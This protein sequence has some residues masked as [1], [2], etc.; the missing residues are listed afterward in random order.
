MSE[1]KLAKGIARRLIVAGVLGLCVAVADAGERRDCTDVEKGL[2]DRQLVAI[3]EDKLSRK[4]LTERHLPFGV[5]IGAHAS[6]GGRKNE[7]LLVQAGY[8]IL[9]DGDLRTTLWTAHRLTGEDVIA[10][11]SKDRV[12][13][14]R[15][16]IRLPDEHAA[17]ERDYNE[18]IFDRGHIT[19]DRDLKDNE[20][21]QINS[22]VLSNIAPQYSRFNQG[23][24]RQIEELGRKW[25]TKHQTVYVSSG[26]LFDFDHKDKRDKDNTAARMGTRHQTARV[27]I[28]SHFYK[29][30]LR[31]N[32]DQWCAIAFLFE[33]HNGPSVGKT[34][35]RLRNAIKPLASIEERAEIK[36]HP[37]LHRTDLEESVDG[38]GWGL[39]PG[40][41]EK[42][43]GFGTMG[44]SACYSEPL[45]E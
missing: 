9:H 15:R 19:P 8:V 13:C 36:F 37:E 45:R 38:S 29:V 39:G 43:G 6:E 41:V 42:K 30:F 44:Q 33:H 18:P 20:T 1:G 10:G 24:W 7:K 16:D 17:I 14:F 28:A 5:H 4:K 27:A 35:Q 25:A 40:N 23:I 22:Y 32:G 31:K 11:E 12:E 3:A 26:A 21:E 2:A 34:R